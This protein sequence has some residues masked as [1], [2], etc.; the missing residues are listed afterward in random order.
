MDGIG[1][2]KELWVFMLGGK[3]GGGGG[4]GRGGGV[5][6]EVE[7]ALLSTWSVVSFLGRWKGIWGGGGGGRKAGKEDYYTLYVWMD[8]WHK[9]PGE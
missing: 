5:R 3:K 1:R 2:N 4:E 6:W 9:M 8:G 7:S